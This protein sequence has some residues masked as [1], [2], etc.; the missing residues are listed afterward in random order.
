MDNMKKFGTGKVLPEQGD[1]QKTAA[2]N[3][4][5]EDEAELAE[6]NKTG[7]HKAE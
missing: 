3:W 2:Q 4:T 7:A 1:D 6:E 5:P